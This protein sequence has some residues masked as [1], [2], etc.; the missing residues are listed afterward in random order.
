[1]RVRRAAI[2]VFFAV[3]T[4]FVLPPVAGAR[5]SGGS[6][7]DPPSWLHVA[8]VGGGR[9]ELVDDA[10]RTV[11]LRGANVAG[12][13]D[14][15]HYTA[16]DEPPW[17]ISPKLYDRACPAMTHGVGEAPLCEVDASK[18]AYQQSFAD[19]ARNDL[20]QIRA[21]GFNVIRLAV[22][23]SQLESTPGTYNAMYIDRIAQVVGWARQQGV[24]V[25]ID[26]HQD[27]YTRFKPE[28][29]PVSVPPLVTPTAQSPNHADGAPRWAVITDGEPAVA[30]FGAGPFNAY[31]AAAF[32]SF[33]HN[34]EPA[35]PVG[36]SP[37]PGLQDHYIG[38]MAALARRFKAESAVVGYEIMNEP[39]PGLFPP[40]AFSTAELYP[41][42]R[43]VIDALT[44]VGD[45]AYADLG[46][47]VDRQAF[48][49]EP[50]AVRN[51]EDA[52]DQ[53]PL[54]FSSY[55]NLV[56]AP[57]VYTH[58]LSGDTLVGIQNSPYPLSYDQA[59]QVAD[60]EAQSMGTALWV[61]EFGNSAGSDDTFLRAATTAQDKARVG[62]A[63][64]QWKNTC[65][66]GDTPEQCANIWSVYAGDGS[67][68]PAQNGPL[69]ASR[70]K[71]LSRVVPRAVAG[72][73]E[74]FAYDPDNRSF[75][76]TATADHSVRPGQR[77][78][79][80]IVFIPATVHGGV[81][82]GGSAVLDRMLSSPDGTRLVYIAPGGG[83][84]T[85]AVS[86]F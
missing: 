42:Y 37:G 82:V 86:P 45:G 39:L 13:E 52:P 62:S 25:L 3:V 68:T 55:P 71:F 1:M 79:E 60:A 80:A 15:Y 32:D 33:W 61:G 44:G 4:A 16:T 67:A 59:F 28:T 29:A 36:A 8:P 20:A 81:V 64:Y 22:S 58:V 26:M 11:L 74:S 30:P 47:H 24:Y 6:S 10:G 84:Y 78:Q 48:F 46:V 17:P 50:M 12:L 72:R 19:G 41:F 76:M 23:W 57:H 70:V 85:V 21:L 5:A 35:V 75:T 14:D 43:K 2:A 53:L 27:D 69:I 34:R 63:V 38:A 54:P 83:S 9:A 56:Y 7:I 18:P 77:E 65:G 31:V 73:L 49:F 51:L 40:V 66:A